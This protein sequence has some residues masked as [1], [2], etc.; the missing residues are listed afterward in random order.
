MRQ[1]G[2]SPIRARYTTLECTWMF[3]ESIRREQ[4]QIERWDVGGSRELS[5]AVQSFTQSLQGLNVVDRKGY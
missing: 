3:G 1:V 5:S 2:D 4:T